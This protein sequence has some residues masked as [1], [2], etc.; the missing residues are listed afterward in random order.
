MAL[1]KKPLTPEAACLKMASL[2]ARS[3]QCEF[4]IARKLQNIGLTATQRKEII[5][6]LKEERYI[7]NQ[8]YSKSFTSDKARFSGWGP[9]KIKA[10]LIA[11]RISTKHINEAISMIPDSVWKESVMKIAASKAKNMDLD[12]D[13]NKENRIKLYRYLLGRGYSSSDAVKAVNT[14]RKQQKGQREE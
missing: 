2:C 4:E 11:K 12:G 9:Y 10:A 13:E 6:Y 7:D 1:K 14:I 5:D 3:E 8:R